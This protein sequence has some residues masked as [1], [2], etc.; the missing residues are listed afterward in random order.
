[1][2]QHDYE[3]PLFENIKALFKKR[4]HIRIGDVGIYQDALTIDMANDN[5]HTARYTTFVK[6]KAVAIFE[7]LVEVEVVEVTIMNSC[8]ENIDALIK[9][10]MPKY[11]NPK[12]I[13]WEIK[14]TVPNV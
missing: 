7:N 12:Y 6:V 2:K 3:I 11:I 10:N 8:N 9:A 13:K 5:I 1:M 4:K 14:E